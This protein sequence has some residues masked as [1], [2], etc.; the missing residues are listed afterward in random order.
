VF[1]DRVDKGHDG[2]RV[3][4]SSYFAPK[5]EFREPLVRSLVEQK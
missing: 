5:S 3:V 1:V 2:R 4:I